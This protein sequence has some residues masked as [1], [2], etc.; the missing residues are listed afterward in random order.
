MLCYR[1]AT[2]AQQAVL[3]FVSMHAFV[4]IAADPRIQ[5]Q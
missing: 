3:T 1:A 4:D 5:T 2:V